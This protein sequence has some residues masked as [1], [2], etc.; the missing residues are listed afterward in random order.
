M[1]NIKVKAGFVVREY[2]LGKS[3]V[4]VISRNA[5]FMVSVIEGLPNTLEWV[6]SYKDLGLDK[7]AVEIGLKRMEDGELVQNAFPSLNED[8]IELLLDHPDFRLG[9]CQIVD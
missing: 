5:P 4:Q 8:Q 3:E 1:T 7:S 6:V 9:D 2:S